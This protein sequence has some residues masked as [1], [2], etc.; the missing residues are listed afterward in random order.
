VGHQWL[1]RYG[2]TDNGVVTVT[3]L[4][5]DGRVYYP[6]HADPYTPAKHFDKG[7][8]DPG[9]RSSSRVLAVGGTTFI[10]DPATGT[11]HSETV[12]NDGSDS[13]TGGGISN[14]FDL[15]PWQSQAEVPDR[16]GTRHKGR[17]VPDVAASAD[18]MTGYQILINGKTACVGGTSAAT[19]LWAALVCRL[20]QALGRPLGLLQPLVYRDLAPGKVTAG[21]RDI[22]A[23]DNGAYAANPGWD[24]N[25]GLGS[26]NGTAL[27]NVLREGD[28]SRASTLSTPT[29]V[30]PGGVER[31]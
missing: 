27:L 16:F 19:P 9:F 8:N 13:A 26:P 14:L 29:R 10:A 11:V 2:K 1:G 6:L 5:S 25:T 22:V 17:G 31:P 20:A 3:T 15:P 30:S 28:A 24:P 21:F 4:W 7:K 12:W 18:S 23:G